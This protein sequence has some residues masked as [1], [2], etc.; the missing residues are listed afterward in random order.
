MNYLKGENMKKENWKYLTMVLV[1]AGV[2]SLIFSS[3]TAFPSEMSV[4]QTNTGETCEMIN[5]GTQ[6]AYII[7]DFDPDE[8]DQM[9]DLLTVYYKIG[10]GDSG[11]S[12]SQPAVNDREPMTGFQVAIARHGTPSSDLYIGIMYPYDNDPFV[13][14]NYILL[15]ALS[16][17]SVPQADTFY[18]FGIDCSG[19][20]LDISSGPPAMSV[21]LVSVDNPDD[22]DYW[23]WGGGSPNPYPVYRPRGWNTQANE[24]QNDML[25]DGW[26]ID[27]CFVTYTTSGGGGEAPNITISTTTWVTTGLGIFSL[28][29]AFLSG[30]K[31]FGW[32]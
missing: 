11:C 27:M 15:G 31:Y 30:S 14:D 13:G 8:L 21:V 20:P 4:N 29:G 25:P 28:I 3:V 16:A 18:W 12:I 9:Q 7:T 24:W 10:V 26:N 19:S 5:I 6:K 32:I 17:S 22:S 1:I 23:M 2:L